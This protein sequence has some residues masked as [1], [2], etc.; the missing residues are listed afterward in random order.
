MTKRARVATQPFKQGDNPE[1]PRPAKRRKQPSKPPNPTRST[2]KRNTPKAGRAAAGGLASPPPTALRRESPLFEPELELTQSAVIVQAEDIVDGDDDDTD[3]VDGDPLP[4]NVVGSDIERGDGAEEDAG[5]EDDEPARTA[6]VSPPF[7]LLVSS[8]IISAIPDPIV[9]IRYRAC[10]G[11]LEKNAIASAYDTARDKHSVWSWVD[12]VIDDLKPRRARIST[13]CAVV[14]PPRQP[15]RDR[16]VKTLRRERDMDWAALSE[17]VEAID[18]AANERIHVDFD[19]ILIEELNETPRSAVNF[20]G[21]GAR[22]RPVTATMIQEDGIAGALAAER[23]GS[24]HAIGIRDRW[25]C[26]DSHC[27]NHPYT[28]WLRPGQPARIEN[29]YPVNDNII[30]MW[31]KDIHDRRATFDEP[32]DN[33]SQHHVLCYIITRGVHIPLSPH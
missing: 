3:E 23:A 9:H 31:A 18:S 30:A 20:A 32:S 24:G 6:I 10:F 19:L 26:I 21:A 15:K 12:G 27:S 4:E 14:Y 1:A 13:L 11:D 25:R 16:A 5:A 28:C 7:P 8:P 2:P 22:T 33:V 17:L 29:H